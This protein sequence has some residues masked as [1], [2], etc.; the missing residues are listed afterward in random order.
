MQLFG[1][2]PT[3]MGC[4]WVILSGKET[5]LV[6]YFNR[7][8]LDVILRLEHRQSRAEEGRPNHISFLLLL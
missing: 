2:T 1:F 3:E 4:Y 8:T 7:F 5:R 6:F